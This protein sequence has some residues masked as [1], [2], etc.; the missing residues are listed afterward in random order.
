MK[1]CIVLGTRPEIIKASPLIRALESRK[2]DYFVIHTGQHYSYNM[3]KIFFEELQLPKPKYNLEI[4]SGSHGSQTGIMLEKI[5]EVLIKE[6]PA[7]VLLIG[8]TNSVLAGALAAAKLHIKVGHI[9]GGLRSYDKDMAEEQNRIVTD[10][11]SDYLFAPSEKAAQILVNEGISKE[12]VF[13]VGNTIVD[14]VYQN[15]ILSEKSKDVLKKFNLEKRKYVVATAHRPENVDNN[16]RLSKIILGLS[17]INSN[18]NLPVIFSAHPRTKNKINEFN[19]RLNDGVKL[20]DP[21]GYLEFLQL[22]NN[23][24]VLVTD[25]GGIQEE[26]SILKVPCVTLR[27]NTERPETVEIGS[28]KIAGVEPESVLQKTIEMMASKRNWTTPYGDGRTAEKIIDIVT[29][30]L[31]A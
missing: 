29:K 8:D 31:K 4:G 20:I 9:E 23:A 22:L 18:T 25:S 12:K 21:L 26:S 24:E 27:D 5:E 17:K 30:N 13:V 3:D 1:I 28:N 10:H 11:L 14:A 7:V 16:I 2:L 15:I 6:K 19:I